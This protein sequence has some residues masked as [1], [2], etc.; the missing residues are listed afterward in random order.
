[1]ENLKQTMAGLPY[2]CGPNFASHCDEY[3]RDG[4]APDFVEDRCGTCLSVESCVHVHIIQLL[5]AMEGCGP[6]IRKGDET[7]RIV[8]DFHEK[9]WNR[10]GDLMGEYAERNSKKRIESH[11]DAVG[12]E[13][14]PRTQDSRKKVSKPK[15]QC[16]ERASTS[17]EKKQ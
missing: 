14:N 16:R 15:Q 12:E 10:I 13:L 17:K 1:M 7:Q 2:R 6:L 3:A 11:V 4:N 5:D 9:C 8:D